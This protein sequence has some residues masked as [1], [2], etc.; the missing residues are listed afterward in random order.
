MVPDWSA[1]RKKC[2]L[3]NRYN[4]L[5]KGQSF[6]TVDIEQW[7]KPKKKIKIETLSQQESGHWLVKSNKHD[8]YVNVSLR[9][10]HLILT[11]WICGY[12][13]AKRSCLPER[14]LQRIITKDRHH[15]NLSYVL[16]ANEKTY[17][18]ENL[19]EI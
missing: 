10:L 13:Y 1:W 4:K 12:N 2:I 11:N 14:K 15:A 18:Y 6:L 3:D 17:S 9:V 19:K 8:E 16:F 7:E 5:L